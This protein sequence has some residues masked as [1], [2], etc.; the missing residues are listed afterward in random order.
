MPDTFGTEH[1][2]F[3]AEDGLRVVKYARNYG[4]VPA[5]AAGQLIPIDLQIAEL[6][7]ALPELVVAAEALLKQAPKIA[8]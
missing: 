7:S 4:F 8:P 3:L 6:D 5:F 2:V 1:D